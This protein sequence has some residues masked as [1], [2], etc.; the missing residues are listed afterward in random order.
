MSCSSLPW[1]GAQM[2]MSVHAVS[3]HVPV[4]HH[5]MHVERKYSTCGI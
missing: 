1:S 2:H 3:N 4:L 5:S